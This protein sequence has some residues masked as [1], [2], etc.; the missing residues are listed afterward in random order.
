LIEILL[1]L[2]KTLQTP[3]GE[4]LFDFSKNLIDEEILA[5]LYK[6]VK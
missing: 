6:L 5:S 4:I 1:Y 3:D 2:R